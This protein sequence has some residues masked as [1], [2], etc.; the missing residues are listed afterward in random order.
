M[1]QVNIITPFTLTLE[2]GRQQ[3]FTTG[4]YEL[5]DELAD[6]WYVRAH[7]DK[8]P[9]PRPPVGTPEYAQQEARKRARRRILDAAIEDAA[10]DEYKGVDEESR[11]EVRRRVIEKFKTNEKSSSA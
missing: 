1:K 7:S 8:A 10:Q 2:G 5:E 3:K 9:P 6:H 4:L 11:N